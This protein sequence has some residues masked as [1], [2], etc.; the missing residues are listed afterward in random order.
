MAVFRQAVRTEADESTRYNMG[1]LARQHPGEIPRERARAQGNHAQRTVET[2]RQK[3]A[4]TLA[5]NK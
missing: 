1:A 4:E 2:H 5:G 3:V